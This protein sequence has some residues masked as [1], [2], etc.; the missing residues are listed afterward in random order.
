MHPYYIYMY[1][2]YTASTPHLILDY[3]KFIFL[4]FYNYVPTS[5]TLTHVHNA[6]CIRV[7]FVI[8]RLGLKLFI[9]SR[10]CKVGNWTR[11]RKYHDV[12]CVI[13]GRLLWNFLWV[14][15]RLQWTVLRIWRHFLWNITSRVHCAIVIFSS[16]NIKIDMIFNWWP[17]S[18][19]YC[20]NILY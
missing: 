16:I 20:I 18:V 11:S 15:I 5:I 3:R 6:H 9:L 4:S 13:N 17:I 2:V 14:L 12:M 7:K 19:L 1:I 10:S 8:Q